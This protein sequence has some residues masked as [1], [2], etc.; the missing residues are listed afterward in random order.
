MTT[1]INHGLSPQNLRIIEDI[2]RKNIPSGVRL[3]VCIFGSRAK[4]THSRYSDVDLLIECEALPAG[5]L[6]KIA[7]SLE[8]TSLP[9]KFDLVDAGKLAPEYK[10]SVNAS[11]RF[12]F[13][14]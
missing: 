14:L 10:L 8:E 9:Y 2:F 5:A 1:E 12:L 4:G 3:V 11:K 13:A 7:E 6:S